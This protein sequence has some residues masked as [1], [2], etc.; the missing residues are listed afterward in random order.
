MELRYR[1]MKAFGTT[2]AG[3]QYNA[4]H[5][6]KELKS[7]DELTLKREPEN[8]HD[9]NAVAVCKGLNR[10]GY[11]PRERA[12]KLAVLLDTGLRFDVKVNG[13]GT[14]AVFPFL[15]IHA[16]LDLES[17]EEMIDPRLSPVSSSIYH[18]FEELLEGKI[19]I[20]SIYAFE[21]GGYVVGT[22]VSPYSDLIGLIKSVEKYSVTI[23]WTL[24]EGTLKTTTYETEKK[25]D[26]EVLE[27]I[28]ETMYGYHKE[29]KSFEKFDIVKHHLSEKHKDYLGYG[30]IVEIEDCLLIEWTESNEISEVKQ[31]SGC[32]FFEKVRSATSDKFDKSYVSGQ[33]VG[34]YDTG[35][36]CEIKEVSEDRKTLIVISSWMKDNKIP[37]VHY[38]INDFRIVDYERIKRE[39]QEEEGRAEAD[40]I[41]QQEGYDSYDDMLY[42]EEEE[43]R[44]EEE[45]MYR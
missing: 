1:D 6:L 34:N 40:L 38:V 29:Y 16:S 8:R 12:S 13:L 43:Q 15:T 5:V 3:L 22:P 44:W 2:V 30:Q 33:W 32:I 25:Q 35:S 42:Q 41:A 9:R 4:T 24:E 39:W 27:A 17:I 20:L 11:I 45:N 36:Y 23:E 19:N 21:Q 18:I 7:G 26:L 14:P 28:K 37:Y 31:Y 10:L